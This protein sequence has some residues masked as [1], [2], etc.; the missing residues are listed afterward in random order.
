MD[1]EGKLVEN[2][3]HIEERIDFHLMMYEVAVDIEKK[4]KTPDLY[5]VAQ[6][7]AWGSYNLRGLGQPSWVGSVLHRSCTT[8]H[9][10]RLGS[11]LF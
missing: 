6:V 9:N 11:R 7:A 2:I 10:G 3:A 1:S 4:K 5:D 8:Y